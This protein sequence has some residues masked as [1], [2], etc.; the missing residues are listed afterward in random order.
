MSDEQDYDDPPLNYTGL[1]LGDS[2]LMTIIGVSRTKFYAMKKAGAYDFLKVRPQLSGHTR[3][4]GT[5]V[6]N[7]IEGAGRSW[8]RGR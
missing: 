7:W 8:R 2:Q 4:S 1:L 6:Q 5:L 3:Y